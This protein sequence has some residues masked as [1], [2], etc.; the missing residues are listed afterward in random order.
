MIQDVPSTDL[1][2]LCRLDKRS[3][4][5]FVT[6]D[7]EPGATSAPLSRRCSFLLP[8]CSLGLSA[9]AGCLYAKFQK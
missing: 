8:S 5:L 9:S 4:S 7:E 1:L 3:D 6:S 2:E